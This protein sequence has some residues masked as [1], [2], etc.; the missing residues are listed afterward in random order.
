MAR[1]Q[2]QRE[3]VLL[4]QNSIERVI[5]TSMRILERSN[6]PDASMNLEDWIELKELVVKLW[7]EERN[8]AFIRQQMVARK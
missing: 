1:T 2:Q 8:R 4:L 7:N 5:N 3:D 6:H